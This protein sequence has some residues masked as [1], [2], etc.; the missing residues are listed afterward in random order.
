MPVAT[1]KISKLSEGMVV[2]W[3]RMII[4]TRRTMPSRSGLI[5]NRP[6]PAAAFSST[7]HVAQQAR[8]IRTGRAADPPRRASRAR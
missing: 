2:P 3:A 7:R 6:R 5:V 1:R 4:G 8:E